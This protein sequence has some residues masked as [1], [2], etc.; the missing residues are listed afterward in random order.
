M[1]LKE[2][3]DSEKLA[4]VAARLKFA[5]ANK[6]VPYLFLKKSYMTVSLTDAKDKEMAQGNYYLPAFII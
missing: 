6:A 1:A 5:E 3:T 2:K 4:I